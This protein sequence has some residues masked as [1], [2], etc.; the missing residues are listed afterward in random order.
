MSVC[1]AIEAMAVVA[2]Q[3][4]A[5]N[6]LVPRGTTQSQPRGS[7]GGGGERGLGGP[8]LASL[9]RAGA[10]VTAAIKAHAAAA[11][12]TAALG[13]LL[14]PLA[15]LRPAVFGLTYTLHALCVSADAQAA[16]ALAEQGIDYNQWKELQRL[17]AL[18]T[19]AGG[20]GRGG[21]GRSQG[22]AVA[23][24]AAEAAEDAP[25]AVEGRARRL[26]DESELV[27]LLS[28]LVAAASPAAAAGPAVEEDTRGEGGGGVGAA[29]AAPDFVSAPV[30]RAGYTP[31]PE[32]SLHAAS[33]DRSPVTRELAAK[34][35]LAIAQWEWA[36]GRI[37]A[38][39]G[40]SLL[41]SLCDGGPG[42]IST[43]C[44]I[45][46][47]AYRLQYNALMHFLCAGVG[48]GSR[49]QALLTDAHSLMRLSR[50]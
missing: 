9:V 42:G 43:P 38:A 1:S 37:V 30:A 50:A 7:S 27:G 22:R 29:A 10:A 15:E 16:E 41:L 11:A 33:R 45:A 28:A 36:R 24:A 26:L 14:P 34:T 49:V 46:A 2:G 6:A 8:F 13:P 5:K 40:L 19:A 39:G 20:P 21:G 12:S 17:A 35:L 32:S 4:P 23:G 31:P 48:E 3:T 47:G 25:A 18:P 44:A